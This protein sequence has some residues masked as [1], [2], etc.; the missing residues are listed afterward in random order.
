[1]PVVIKGLKTRVKYFGIFDFK[2]IYRDI[3]EKLTDLG[4]M[5]SYKASKNM[6]ETYYS[7]KRSSDPREAKTM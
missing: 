1:M 6:M 7:E 4:Y 2:Q 5:D 3:K